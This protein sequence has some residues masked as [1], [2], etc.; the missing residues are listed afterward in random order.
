[1][2][3][4]GPGKPGEECHFNG[5][6][7]FSISADFS[8]EWLVETPDAMVA[9]SPEGAVLDWNRAAEAMFGF[10]RDEA[11]GQSLDLIVPPDKAAEERQLQHDALD[12]E[13]AAYESVRRRKD[14]SLVHVAVSTKAIRGDNKAEVKYFLSTK[15]DVTHLKVMRDSKLVEAKYRFLASMSH[16]LRTP[17]NA[18]LGF[19]G[20]LLME[21]PGPLT[22]EQRRQLETVRS[23]ARHQ[24]SLINDLLDLAK[25][26]SGKVELQLEPVD[27]AGLVNEV[28]D[29]LR[30]LAQQKG[31]SFETNSPQHIVVR[32]D[33][34]ALS[35]ILINLV[36]NA[37][38]FTEKG[39][40][41]IE[42]QPNNGSTKISVAD[43]GIGINRADQMK[44]FDA[45]ARV[46]PGSGKRQEGTGLGLHLSQKLAGLLGGVITF[47]SEPG[48]GS[49]FTLS[50]QSQS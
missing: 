15:K 42:V 16:E 29:T 11:V 14:G 19:T 50:I 30:S 32:T 25:I 21:L 44:L 12:H 5:R 1:M 45:F 43:T 36:N 17:L 35:Q 37:I 48:R 33:R 4:S 3:E 9:F 31:L 13:I 6:G 28:A 34:R 39:G 38:K 8:K 7:D 10:T 46:Q 20:T 2:P 26:D 40:V 27:C 41:R 24:L 47:E 23:S 49:A 18:I 22:P